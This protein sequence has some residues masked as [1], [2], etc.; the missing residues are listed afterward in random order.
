MLAPLRLSA[1]S[2]EED[3]LHGRRRLH[4][5]A[6]HRRRGPAGLR[7]GC[8]RPRSERHVPARADRRRR[9][10]ARPVLLDLKESAQLGMGPHGLCVGA[11]GSGKS[12][13]L[14]TLVL[15]PAG[16]APA[17]RTWRWSWST[18]RVAR[19]SRRS[20][21]CRTSP[22]SSP[23]WATTPSLIERAYASLAGEVKRRQQV[24]KDAGNIANISDYRLLP[25]AAA[26]PGAAAAPV[27]R[28]RRV[29]RTAHRAAGL[30]RPVPV[31]RPDRPLHRRAPAAVQPADRGRQAARAGHLPLV[32]ARSAHVLRGREPD[33]PGHHGR[34]PPAAAAR[35]RLPQG[36]HQRLPAVQGGYVSGAYTG[37]PTGEPRG[38][39]RRRSGRPCYAVPATRP[40]PAG[41]AA[42]RRRGRRC[43]R[44][45]DRAD[46]AGRLRR[47]RSSRPLSRCRQIWL[48][49][50]P[51]ASALDAV[52][53][54]LRQVGP[55]GM[56]LPVRSPQL[57]AAARRARRPAPS[58]GRSVTLDLTV[59]G[60]HAAVI[61]GPQSGKTTA[62]RTL[63]I[64]LALTHTPQE[65]AIYGLDL[66]GG[67]LQ[68]LRDLPHVGGVAVRTDRE[69]IRRTVEEIRGMIDH[70]ERVFRE[71][72]IDSIEAL[73]D[74]HAAGRAAR[75]A[76]RRHRAGH[77]RL[78]RD[79]RRLRRAGR[80]DLRHPAARRRLRHP[81]RGGDAALERR[82]DAD[83]SNVRHD[84]RAAAERPV[85]LQHRPHA[86]RRPCAAPSPAAC[87]PATA[88]SSRRSRCPGSTVWS[89]DANL[90]AGPG[91]Q[92]VAIRATWSGALAPPVRV[93]P[94]LVPRAGRAEL[95]RPSRSGC[96]SAWT[97][98]ALAPVLLDLSGGDSNLVVFGDSEC[99]KT[100]LLRLVDPAAR[101]SATQ[102]RRAGLRGD[103]PAARPDRRGE[104]VPEDVHRRLRAQRPAG[105]PGSPA[106]IATELEKR[107][108]DDAGAVLEAG[109]GRSADRGPRRR[110][111][112]ADHRRAVA[113]G[114]V[115]AVHPVRPR[116]R[117]CTSS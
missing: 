4:R 60:G 83:Q 46:R 14:R 36:R 27:R 8:G 19:R 31:D 77:R 16:H 108:P 95:G 5:P 115:P 102:R 1:E 15:G 35:L 50:L 28:H 68:A 56:Q 39:G 32:P 103:G 9:Q 99:G 26:G 23:T 33:G 12:E 71:H 2:L 37:R 80:A 64:S 6:R 47:T 93:L 61:G 100:N 44:A 91:A 104:V 87:S 72:G 29:R 22:A 45:D 78:R 57:R 42:G 21:A 112:P 53:G 59:A 30:H 82:P 3:A 40:R 13:L 84:A 7:R 88:S 48:P 92:A 109:S 114:P 25:Q 105:V 81:R 79:P 52:G 97:R 11:T 110:L 43:D 38:R 20:R 101:S 54:P 63:V 113:A 69:R 111:R 41:G 58:S 49:P 67:G 117:S 86:C 34:L 51:A 73:R 106:A 74:L 17:R 10:P 65:V 18:T 55:R 62:L 75:A 98:P 85:R 94:L 70:R 24:L 90:G 76:V 116:H 66:V 107:L 89:D 96:R